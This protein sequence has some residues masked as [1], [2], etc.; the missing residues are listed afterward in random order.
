MALAAR[1]TLAQPLR[2]IDPYQCNATLFPFAAAC[3]RVGIHS[4]SCKL[5]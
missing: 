1:Q 5:G 3:G 2:M 4:C